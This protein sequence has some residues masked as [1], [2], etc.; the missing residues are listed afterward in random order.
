MSRWEALY[1]EVKNNPRDVRFRD[2]CNLVERFGFVFRGRRGSHV[3]YGKKSVFEI[4]NFQ[5]VG[6]K[7][8]PCQVRQFLKVVEKYHLQLE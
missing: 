7:A 1:E 5:E 8:K 6:G 3:V 2:L 4:L